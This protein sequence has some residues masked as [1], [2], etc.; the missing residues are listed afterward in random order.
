LLVYLLIY[1]ISRVTLKGG[2]VD[3]E[4]SLEYIDRLSVQHRGKA[5]IPA[6]RLLIKGVWE[7]KTYEQMVE[8]TPFKRAYLQNRLASIL[9]KFLSDALGTTIDKPI[10]R[11]YLES[12]SHLK[13]YGEYPTLTN[14]VGRET[15]LKRLNEL[16]SH[17]RCLCVYGLGGMGKTSLVSQWLTLN[18][19]CQSQWDGAIWKSV[20]IRFDAVKDLIAELI[21][22]TGH[23]VNDSESLV[24]Q[25]IQ[26]LSKQRLLII[27]DSAEELLDIS[28]RSI[29]ESSEIRKFIKAIQQQH[30]SC[31]VF[32]GR[33]LMPGFSSLKNNIYSENVL[34]IS[35]LESKWA[36]EILRSYSL[37]EPELWGSLIEKYAA[38]PLALKITASYIQEY[39]NEKVSSFNLLNTIFL[40]K[41]FEEILGE[42]Y[43]SLSL[44][45]KEL[46]YYLSKGYYQTPSVT[47]F[48]LSRL[49][50][51]FSG[52]NLLRVIKDLEN[53]S[54]L[55]RNTGED[56]SWTLQPVIR[57]YFYS[58]L[59]KDV[60]T[61]EFVY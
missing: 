58:F 59:N 31:I 12:L 25:F 44:E 40:G 8:G 37:K 28:S 21:L 35:G 14:F 26:I 33:E 32:I 41:E 52:E 34:K 36:E 15:E 19:D 43:E 7:G 11:P 3:L 47:N 16:I 29:S 54:L 60:A 24:R 51:T 27:I 5:L 38:N 39:F 9:W 53:K 48:S 49:R 1:E 2:C 46:M 20:T 17:S 23:K 10:L 56:I 45:G 42:Q 18:Q 50:N 55:E 13:V 4:Q 57:K 61:H 22:D 30:L 6:E